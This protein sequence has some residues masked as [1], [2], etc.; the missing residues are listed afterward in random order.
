MATIN[1]LKRE[2][3]TQ[4]VYLTESTIEI[5]PLLQ[6]NYSYILDS[7]K[8]EN[9][10]LKNEKCNLFKEM[11]FDCKV[12]GFCSYDFSREFM[13]A[14]LNNIYILPEFRGN[15]LFL[16]ELR[17]TMSEHNK[18]SIMEPTR[19]VVELLIKYGYAEMINENI[20]ASAIEFVV[21]GEHVIA[22]REIETEEELSTHFYDLNICASIHLLNVDKCLIAYSLALNDD[23]IRYDC[24]EKRSEINDNYFKR[25]KELF[26]NNDS[27]ILDT[28]VNLEEKLPLKTLTLE[29]VIGSDD[30]LS[31]YIE[32]LIDDAHVTYSDALKIRDQIKEE[33]EAGMIVN[34]S[35]LI[36]L[37]YL[38]NIPEEARLITHDEKCPY[39]DMPIDSHD[40]YCHYCG[41]NLNYNPDEV[42][43][44]LISSINQFSD[45]IYPN[46]DIRYIAYKFLKMI[47]EKIEFEYAM[48][49][50]ESN[51][52]IT[53]KRLKKYLND[54]NYINSENITQEGIDFLN[55][56][57]LHYYEK[58]HMDIVDYSKFE[59][60]FWKNSD[61]NKEEI[62]LKFLDK[63]DDEEI[64]EIKEE[65]KRNIS[66]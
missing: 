42:E 37:A 3:N 66:L 57:P 30:E 17:K 56:H 47:Y 53:Q 2:N 27:E 21:P 18:P 48:F 52:N 24:M 7:M 65:I 33:Y 10:I 43:N 39:C 11:V 9:F 28:L 60:F 8:K 32:T 35:L 12:V 55:N 14:A 23:I 34:E 59:D 40:K 38:F 26:I 25:I 46:E 41:I 29:E 36:R 44:N 4:K 54:N 5:T 49:M 20:V 50:C 13:T 64:E 51:Y 31:H 1:Y 15:G 61:L 19:F 6:D 63:Y 45:E 16:E 58:Y 22:N 62:C